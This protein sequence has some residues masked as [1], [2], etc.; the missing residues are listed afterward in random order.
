M[1]FDLRQWL[2]V[3]GPIVIAGVLVHGYVRMRSGQNQIKMKLDKSFVSQV[4]ETDGVD[5]L[6]LLRAELPNGGARVIVSDPADEVPVLEETVDL[7]S[8][9]EIGRAHV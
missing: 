4:G 3:L 9:S 7:P 8:S 2:L 5:D 6:N 1:D